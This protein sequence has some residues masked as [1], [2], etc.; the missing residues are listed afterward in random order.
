MLKLK[1]QEHRLLV[2]PCNEVP[3][4]KRSCFLE[5]GERRNCSEDRRL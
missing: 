5:K 3:R 4:K 1:K 2:I